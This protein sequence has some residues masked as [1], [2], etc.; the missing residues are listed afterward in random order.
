[1][2]LIKFSVRATVVYFRGNELRKR[3]RKLAAE[4]GTDMHRVQSRSESLYNA[5]AD[6]IKAPKRFGFGKK[7]VAV[8]QAELERFSSRQAQQAGQRL[9]MHASRQN[10][11]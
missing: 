4:K 2:D 1:M 11:A 8:S 3:Q 9:S 10:A 6:F 7:K 5:R